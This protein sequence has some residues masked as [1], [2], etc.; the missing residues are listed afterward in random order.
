MQ[1]IITILAIFDWHILAQADLDML[2]D[3]GVDTVL[4][5]ALM[6]CVGG[7]ILAAYNLMLGNISH[8]IHII[9]GSLLMGGGGYVARAAFEMFE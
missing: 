4:Q 7:I 8:A 5:F 3:E 6:L 1:S 9:L 2:T